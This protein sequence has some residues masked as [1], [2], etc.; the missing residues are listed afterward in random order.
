MKKSNRVI[1]IMSIIF[2]VIVLYLTF[3]LLQLNAGDIR[4]AIIN[5]TKDADAAEKY[6]Q[7]IYVSRL[8]STFTILGILSIIYIGSLGLYLS[9]TKKKK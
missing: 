5:F 1:I 4:G 6:A 7:E 2:V 3:L 8:K 9:K